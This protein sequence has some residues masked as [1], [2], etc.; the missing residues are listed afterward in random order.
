MEL[1][2]AGSHAS[3]KGPV[4][5]FTGAVR[6]DPLNAPPAPGKNV[7]WLEPVTDEQHLAGPRAQG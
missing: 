6:I 7:N 3:V 2:R 4:E 1:K 5:W